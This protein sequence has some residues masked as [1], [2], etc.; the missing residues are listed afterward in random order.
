MNK[1]KTRNIT[2]YTMEELREATH[3]KLHDRDVHVQDIADIVFELQ[4]DYFEDLTPEVCREMLW[5]CFQRGKFAT[6]Y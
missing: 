5:Q 2:H 3:K 6:P 1:N 4:T